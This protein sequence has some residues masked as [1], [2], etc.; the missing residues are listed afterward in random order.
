MSSS[1]TGKQTSRARKTGGGDLAG[2]LAVGEHINS[3]SVVGIGEC[4]LGFVPGNA[5][6]ADCFEAYWTQKDVDFFLGS[7]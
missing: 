2:L 4:V 1:N 3:D 7:P 5:R 6:R